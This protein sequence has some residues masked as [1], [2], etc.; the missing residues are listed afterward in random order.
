MAVP[1]RFSMGVAQTRR[2]TRTIVDRDDNRIRRVAPGGVITTFAGTGRSAF[3]GDGGLA[4]AADLSHPTAGFKVDAQGNVFIAD[5]DNQV[6]RKITKTT[7]IITTVAGNGTLAAS[8]DGGPATGAG[9]DPFGIA[10]DADGSLYISDYY[11][12]RIRKVT[13]AGVITTIARIGTK[14]YSGDNGPATSAAINAPAGIVVDAQKNV[15]LVDGANYRVRKITGSDRRHHDG[16]GQ[17]PRGYN[18]GRGSGHRGAPIPSTM[19]GSRSQRRLVDRQH[20]RYPARDGVDGRHSFP[21]GKHPDYGYLDGPASTAI[22]G[23]ISGITVAANGDIYASD[24]ANTRV[25]RIASSNVSAFAGAGL[26]N[27]VRG[28][29]RDSELSRRLVC[30]LTG[31]DLVRRPVFEPNSIAGWGRVKKVFGDG[32]PTSGLKS[33]RHS[34]GRDARCARHNVYRRRRETTAFEG[35]PG[36]HQWEASG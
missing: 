18:R 34:H 6:V 29:Q 20:L 19:A 10:L 27:D 35:R 21:Y 24:S 17:W 14:G 13:A 28:D 8:G 4:T 36:Q 25:R 32:Y 26:L 16:G 11:N 31:R 15:Y 9:V 3:K 33:R 7:G 12:H 22:W 2:G 30:P 1:L 23:A 5:Y